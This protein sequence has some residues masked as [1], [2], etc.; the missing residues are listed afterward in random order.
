MEEKEILRRV[1]IIKEKII[2]LELVNS[3]KDLE[4]QTYDFVKINKVDSDKLGELFNYPLEYRVF[5]EQIGTIYVAY[6]GCFMLE[7]ILPER[8]DEIWWADEYSNNE[9]HRILVHTDNDNIEF[10][11]YDISNTPFIRIVKDNESP[12][13]DFLDI[14][15]KKLEGLLQC[16]DVKYWKSI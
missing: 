13:M 2:E 8:L 16:G 12:V 11:I 15:E 5:L 3:K 10:V 9:N 7:V 14:V 6:A 4:E 1:L